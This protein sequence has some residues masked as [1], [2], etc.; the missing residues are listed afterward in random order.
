MNELIN[1]L[2]HRLGETLL[3]HGALLAVAESCT[4]GW[5]AKALTDVPGS[6]AWFDRGF[7]TYSNESKHELLGVDGEILRLHG[8][9]S[10]AVVRAMAQGALEHSRA[11]L[12]VAVAL[13]TGATAACLRQGRGPDCRERP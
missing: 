3:R 2:P 1:V 5:I 8:A 6:S 11:D 13:R 7:V 9:V 12:T 4:G 10:E